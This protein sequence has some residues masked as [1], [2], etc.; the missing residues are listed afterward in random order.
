MSEVGLLKA[1]IEQMQN[2]P[3]S[4]TLC[5]ALIALGV[6]L[7]VNPIFP[8]KFIPI[9]IMLL[10]GAINV[11]VGDLSTVAPD[12]RNPSVVLFLVGFLIGFIA[13]ILRHTALKRFEKFL[14]LPPEKA[15]AQAQAQDNPPSH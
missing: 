13:W 8:D 9:T 7:K 10:G 11:V 15:A 14:P 12:Q 2:W 4:L 1:F 5:L 6:V 3:M